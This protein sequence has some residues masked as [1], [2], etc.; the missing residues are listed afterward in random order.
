MLSFYKNTVTIVN[1]SRSINVI[2]KNKT[3]NRPLS[4]FYFRRR[5]MA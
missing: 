2:Y 1:Q 4:Y 3:E 5:N